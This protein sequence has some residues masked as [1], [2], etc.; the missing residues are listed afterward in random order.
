MKQT[1][2]AM[3]VVAGTM[4][5]CAVPVPADT[6]AIQTAAAQTVIAQV[7]ANARTATPPPRQDAPALS[8]P[9]A[10]SLPKQPPGGTAQPKQQPGGTGQPQ[11][12]PL[13]MPSIP[14]PDATRNAQVKL[15]LTGKY[16]M[17]FHACDTAKADC[18]DP[19]NH[20]VYLA[21]G[22]DG[23]N[24]SIVPGWLAYS[25]S[26]PDV[27][28]RGNTIYIYTPGQVTRYNTETRVFQGPFQVSIKTGETFVDPSFIVDE[29]G[30]LVMFFLYGRMGSD[31]AGCPPGQSK[32]QQ[33]FG[34]ATEVAGSDGS[35]FTLDEGDRAI[36]EI[37]ETSRLR[38]ASDPDI[39]F[40]GQQFVLYISHGPSLSL[41]TSAQ[42]RGTYKKNTAFADELFV[43]GGSGIGA[44]HYDAASK[45]Y[46]TYGHRPSGNQPTMIYR[47][48]HSDFSRQLGQGDFAPVITGASLGLSA[49]THVESPGFAVNAP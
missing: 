43:S 40:D 1:L 15:T 39:F 27:I 46:W 21:Q 20:N 37:V 19:R 31:P 9:I 23:K 44:G 29:Q 28:R 47:A 26:V 36:V 34:S 3:L 22:D 18:F 35:Q 14:T 16:L 7:A 41:W 24:W 12:P 32:C 48:V 11:Q 33:R 38:S 25:G 13:G 10:T 49:T 8:S 45:Q 30:R 4:G 17:S 6:G 2:V 5:A 42:L